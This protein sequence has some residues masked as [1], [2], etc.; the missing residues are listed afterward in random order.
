MKLGTKATLS[1]LASFAISAIGCGK[2]AP[3][4][5][6]APNVHKQPISES[7]VEATRMAQGNVFRDACE[8]SYAEAQLELAAALDE[9][10]VEIAAIAAQFYEDER[11]RVVPMGRSFVRERR[12][13]PRP[14]AGWFTEEYGWDGYF[15]RF[16]AIKDQPVNQEW[17][18]LNAGVRGTLHDDYW[19]TK[20][21]GDYYVNQTDEAAL[22]SLL[23]NIDQCLAD[24]ACVSPSIDA[25]NQALIGKVP[26]FKRTM[27]KLKVADSASTQREQL[28]ELKSEVQFALSRFERLVNPTVR[29]SSATEL[30]LPLDGGDFGDALA[31]ISGYVESLWKS[32][33]LSLKIQW[34]AADELADVF[35]IFA[36]LGSGNRSYVNFEKRKIVL[37]PYVR[38]RSIAHEIGHALGISDRYYTTWN[39]Q[40]CK[41]SDASR[42]E[43]LMS[44]PSTGYVTS[45]SWEYL[46]KA[47]PLTAK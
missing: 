31:Q 46:D 29:R 8:L 26:V 42:P 23:R 7:A 27:E 9:K 34:T 21:R 40:T 10:A 24:T 44:D 41:Y 16:R 12:N 19:R 47:Y 45:D 4:I 22:E 43:D 30:V 13:E 36:G 5:Q 38:S 18:R 32:D 17:V 15:E 6:A 37:Y 1:L 39:P 25:T 35:R 20:G 14:K 2:S 11:W 33:K 28:S 3:A